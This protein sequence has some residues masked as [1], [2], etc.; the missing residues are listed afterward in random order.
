M[1]QEKRVNIQETINLL[2]NGYVRYTKDE[3]EPGKSVQSFYNLN[4]VLNKELF[5][6]PK[7]KNLKTKHVTMLIIDD[8]EEGSPVTEVREVLPAAAGEDENSSANLEEGSAITAAAPVAEV[9]A[10]VAGPDIFS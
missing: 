9:A 1:A 10:V 2:N 4:G 7:L 8:T 5:T 3:R 6:H